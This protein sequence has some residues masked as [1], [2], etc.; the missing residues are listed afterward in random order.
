MSSAPAR[1]GTKNGSAVTWQ[2]RANLYAG[3]LGQGSWVSFCEVA[4]GLLAQPASA[5]TSETAAAPPTL[6]NTFRL[7][8]SSAIWLIPERPYAA[9]FAD[10]VVRYAG[11]N[12]I[13]LT[14]ND[15]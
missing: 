11:I 3:C 13:L 7:D 5:P 14:R 8:R 6:R 2:T 1:T 10:S 15:D 9:I 4:A 12:I